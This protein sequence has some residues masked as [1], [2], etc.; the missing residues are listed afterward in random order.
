MKNKFKIFLFR[1]SEISYLMTKSRSK[2]GLSE[3]TKKYLQEVYIREEYGRDKI[4]ANKYMNKGTV[5]EDTSIDLYAEVFNKDLVVKNQKMY[6]NEYIHGTPD[7]ILKDKIVD[8]KTSW[9]IWSY[10]SADAQRYYWQIQAYMWLTGRTKG[11]IAFCLVNALQ[12]DVMNEQYRQSFLNP[13]EYNTKA[14]MDYEMQVN[15]QIFKNMTYDD[16]SEKLRVKVTEF[17]YNQENI[18]ELIEKIKMAREY[19]NTININE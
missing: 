10:A 7:I 16:I 6:S 2:S 11:E 9:D 13:Y 1:P 17:E 3:T 5:L 8:I 12:K 18:N 15:D 4:F 14:H 19:L